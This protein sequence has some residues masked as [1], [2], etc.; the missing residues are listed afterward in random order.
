[1]ACCASF[2]GRGKFNV[3]RDTAPV[4]SKGLS[5]PSSGFMAVMPLS[6]IPIDKT[7]C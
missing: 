5:N 6:A 2:V 4:F 3:Q 7:I 1:M